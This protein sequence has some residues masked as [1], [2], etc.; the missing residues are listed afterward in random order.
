MHF[1]YFRIR[2]FADYSQ[3]TIGTQ[4][5]INTIKRITNITANY[6]YNVINVTR[7]P[8]LYYPPDAPLKCN[9]L[10]IEEKYVNEGVIG[11]MGTIIGN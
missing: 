2:I 11:D 9:N 7:L 4:A 5:E 8:R 1:V 3:V 6:F 10:K